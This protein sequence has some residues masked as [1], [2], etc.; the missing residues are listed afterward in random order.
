MQRS[1]VTVI[2]VLVLGLRFAGAINPKHRQWQVFP[3]G[4]L[5]S[6]R[7]HLHASLLRSETNATQTGH[8]RK[9]NGP[10]DGSPMKVHHFRR[11]LFCGCDAREDGRQ[12]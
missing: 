3:D 9:Q 10:V 2:T 8:Y 6:T 4:S 5:L 1:R 11:C 7:E 12:W